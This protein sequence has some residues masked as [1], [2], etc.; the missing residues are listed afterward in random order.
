MDLKLCQIHFMP[1]IKAGDNIAQIIHTALEKQK[2]QLADD[3]ILV[4]TSKIISKAENRFIDLNDVQPSKKAIELA[5]ICKKDA[6]LVEIILSESK[7]IIRCVKNTLIVEHRLGFIC[8]NAG[9]DHSN[10][11]NIGIGSKTYLLLPKNPDASAKIIQEHFRTKRNVNIGVMI[12]DSYGRAWRK[13]V[14]GLMIGTAGV[15]AL[16]D[17]RGRQDIFGSKLRITQIAAADELAASASLV[18]GQANEQI[19]VVHVRGFPYELQNSKFS[20]ILRPKRKDL[21]R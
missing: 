1:L 20:E 15:P 6:R 19:P 5:G 16:V 14:V 8:A 2:I 17:M 7:S 11:G 4:I 21:F 13:G 10:I 9:V 18:M 12:I 3:D